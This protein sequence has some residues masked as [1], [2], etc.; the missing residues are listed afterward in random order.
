MSSCFS[1]KGDNR[2]SFKGDRT[3]EEIVNFATRLSGP[4]I[5]TITREE[6]LDNIKS[7]HSLFFIYVGEQNGPLWDTYAEVAETFQPHGFFYAVSSLLVKKH[8]T[9]MRSPTLFVFK[10][11]SYYF[12]EGIKSK[13]HFYATAHS[14]DVVMMLEI[15]FRLATKANLQNPLSNQI[16]TPRQ[17]FEQTSL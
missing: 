14:T 1:L 3:L 10:E 6:S 12:F 11:N 2:Y 7:S 8:V 13:F 9:L 16:M 4:P 5:Q 17:L 15:V